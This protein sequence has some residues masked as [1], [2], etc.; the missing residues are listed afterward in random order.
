MSA[1]PLPY[2]ILVGAGE[3]AC[4]FRAHVWTFA[5]P[6]YSIICWR[7]EMGRPRHSGSPALRRPSINI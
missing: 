5:V 6:D 4:Q 2:S 1:L 7:Y 3:M